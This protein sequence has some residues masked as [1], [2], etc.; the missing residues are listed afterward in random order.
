MVIYPFATGTP[1]H[2]ND[3]RTD[4]PPTTADDVGFTKAIITWAA[5]NG[6]NTN[7]VY[8]SGYS[9]GGMFSYR[10]GMEGT[11]V[12]AFSAFC[13]NMPTNNEC[14]WTYNP[15]PAFICNGTDDDVMPF[16][17]GTIEVFGL[18]QGEVYSTWFTKEWWRLYNGT[19]ATGLTINWPNVNTTDG[20]TVTSV[21][22]YNGPQ[23]AETRYYEVNGGGHAIPST[24]RYWGVFPEVQPQNRDIEGVAHA[25]DM[26]R[27]FTLNGV[28]LQGGTVPAPGNFMGPPNSAREFTTFWPTG[29]T[30]EIIQTGGG[31][32]TVTNFGYPGVKPVVGDYDGDGTN[33]LAY[34]D[35]SSYVWT[36][37]KSS[38]GTLVQQLGNSTCTLVPEDYDG[39]GKT[40]I[41]VLDSSYVWH[42]RKS[43]SGWN[44]SGQQFGFYPCVPVAADYD[45]DNKADIGVMNPN[46]FTWYLQRTSAGFTTFQYGFG[47]CKPVPAKYDG[48]NNADVAVIDPT[49]YNWYISR[50]T[51]GTVWVQQFGYAGTTW[52]PSDYN[53]GGKA[54]IAVWDPVW[55]NWYYMTVPQ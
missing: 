39:D 43:A 40:D 52:V 36:V 35:M 26:F 32:K 19:T 21:R 31:G 10:L 14:G 41:A 49:T 54:D 25:W 1:P 24:S 23:R 15:T 18:N 45:G 9:N 48:D 42:F 5:Q 38:G 28:T 53:G 37:A 17:G 8:A 34:V 46:G 47:S 50:S 16:V 6:G 55:F 20:C 33:D 30:W 4:G 44:Y 7:R 27:K 29:G 22:Y 51:A 11:H 3:C 13:A 12:A 2:W